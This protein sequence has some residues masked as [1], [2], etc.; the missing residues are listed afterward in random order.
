MVRARGARGTPHDRRI[1]RHGL[2]AAHRRHLPHPLWHS[3]PCARSLPPPTPPPTKTV[4]GW[5][6]CQERGLRGHAVDLAQLA[7]PICWPQDGGPYL[8]LAG[9]I[10]RDPTTGTRNVGLYRVQV[11]GKDAVAMHWQRHKVGAAHWREMAARGE[12]IPGAS[13]LGGRPA[14][15]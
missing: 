15:V 7:A 10:T 4:G 14:G 6:P 9:V 3:T 13:P 11:L 8:T 2:R 1:P 5:P 12:T